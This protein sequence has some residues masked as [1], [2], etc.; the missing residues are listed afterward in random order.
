[1]QHTYLAHGHMI[2]NKMKVHLDVLGALML[3]GIR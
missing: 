3:D 1:M 2:A